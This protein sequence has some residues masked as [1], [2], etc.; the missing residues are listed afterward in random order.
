[1]HRQTGKARTLV[2]EG[3][4][5]SGKTLF[6]RFL[7]LE[8]CGKCMLKTC[9]LKSIQIKRDNPIILEAATTPSPNEEQRIPSSFESRR[10]II[11]GINN[12]PWGPQEQTQQHP[13]VVATGN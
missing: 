4:R 8:W 6:C 9:L 2:L 10:G 3:S 7:C 13:Q 11:A 1:M 12:L 5:Q